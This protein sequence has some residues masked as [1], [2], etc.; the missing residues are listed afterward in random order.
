MKESVSSIER[1]INGNYWIGTRYDGLICIPKGGL[2]HPVFINYNTS[3]SG[4]LADHILDMVYDDVNNQ[5]WFS[6]FDALYAFDVSTHECRR[7]ELCTDAGN[8]W[9]YSLAI[10]EMGHCWQVDMVFSK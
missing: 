10:T 5:L 8:L 1:D 3:N 7:I 4:I 6:S 2:D 9:L